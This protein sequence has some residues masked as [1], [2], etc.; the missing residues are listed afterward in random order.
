[1]TERTSGVPPVIFF[2]LFR[3]MSNGG[4]TR[5]TAS[6]GMSSVPA[7]L[8]STSA[9]ARFLNPFPSLFIGPFFNFFLATQVALHFTPVSRSV[10]KWA[11]FR[12]SVAW[13]LRACFFLL[14]K[15]KSILGEWTC[16]ECTGIM[17]RIAE[18]MK[19][20]DTIAQGV[21]VLTES[22]NIPRKLEKINAGVILMNETV[23]SK[24]VC[25]NWDLR[26]VYLPY[27]RVN[28]SVEPRVTP[29]T[30]LT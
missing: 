5:Q 22:F 9:S 29:L 1:M 19:E 8:A 28:A 17:T 30:V 2:F 26:D 27:I 12:T 11:E 16:D 21:D 3:H 24:G 25:S 7:M 14:C 15:V 6:T 4:M 13:S 10:S 20:P 18:F 23:P